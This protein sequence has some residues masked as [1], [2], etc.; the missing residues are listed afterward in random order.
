ME[1][2]HEVMLYIV[3]NGPLSSTELAKRFQWSDLTRHNWI[4]ALRSWGWITPSGHVKSTE[5]GQ[6]AVSDLE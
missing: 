6:E 3:K 5:A 1:Y 2:Y 4:K